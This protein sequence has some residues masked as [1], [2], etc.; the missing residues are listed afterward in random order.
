MEASMPCLAPPPG[1]RSALLPDLAEL[2]ADSDTA[3]S[4]GY[5]RGGVLP[6]QSRRSQGE[7]Q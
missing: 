6:F 4:R 3:V 7:T 1:G 2:A 5:V